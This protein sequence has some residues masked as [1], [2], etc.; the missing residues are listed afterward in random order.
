MSSLKQCTVHKDLWFREDRFREDK[1]PWCQ[2][3]ECLRNAETKLV[4]L[5]SDNE[6]LREKLRKHQ[7]DA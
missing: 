1:C 7:N 5:T 6:Y 4:S 2:D 3:I